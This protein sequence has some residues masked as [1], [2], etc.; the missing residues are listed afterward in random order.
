MTD[1]FTPPL[2]SAEDIALT[3][4]ATANLYSRLMALY[5]MTD[6]VSTYGKTVLPSLRM[7][8]NTNIAD[9]TSGENIAALSVVAPRIWELAEYLSR[10]PEVFADAINHPHKYLNAKHRGLQVSDWCISDEHFVFLK[11]EAVVKAVDGFATLMTREQLQDNDYDSFHGYRFFMLNQD[12]FRDSYLQNPDEPWLSRAVFLAKRN[13]V[14]LQLGQTVSTRTAKSELDKGKVMFYFESVNGND[15]VSLNTYT[16]VVSS[17]RRATEAKVTTR[18]I[19]EAR[20]ELL[21]QRTT[22]AGQ[23]AYVR[24]QLAQSKFL[25]HWDTLKQS[26]QRLVDTVQ[27]SE[28]AEQWATIPIAESGTRTERTWGIEVETV[29]ANKT[30][31]PRGWDAHSDGSLESDDDDSY[32][33]C[34]CTSCYDGEHCERSGRDC[35][36][37]DDGC[38]EFVSPI[39]S[40]FNSEGL[41]KLCNDI[42][43]HEHNTTPGIHVHVGAGDLTVTD[44]ARL[45]YAYG[46][47]ERFLVPLYHRETTSYCKETPSNS[48]R[49]WLSAARSYLRDTG[50]VPQPRDICH[51]QPADRYMDVNTYALRAHG[52]IE[53]RAMGP[54]YDYDHLVRWAW[55]VRQMVA[56]SRLDLPQQ[57]WN[58]CTSLTDVIDILRKYGNESVDTNTE[59]NTA[60]DNYEE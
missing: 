48:V 25:A 43:T 13:E 6:R 30:S 33:D 51:D 60:L 52:T 24:K 4:S 37:A 59:S 15:I 1:V 46:I 35:N 41:R 58:A 45:L 28:L 57:V 22:A 55:F 23:E 39:L 21:A 10:T 44:V 5:R 8:S 12:K 34:D 14:T 27:L 49:W 47:V 42:P 56:V 26:K 20:N 54:Y 38:M 3:E 9:Q 50:N 17:V 16:N 36:Y 32:C 53:F 11:T 18:H 19:T 31:R 40:H 2:I 29:R 7:V